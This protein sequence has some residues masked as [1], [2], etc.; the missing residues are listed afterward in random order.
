[1]DSENKRLTPIKFLADR[2]DT[3]WGSIEYKLAD[4]GFIDSMASEGWLGG[5]TI[6]DIMQT[7]LERIS[8]ETSFDWYG[9]QFPVLIKRISAK[10][11]TPF[12]VNADDETAEQR[13]DAFGKTALWYVLEAGKDA[14]LFLGFKKEVGARQLFSAWEEGKVEGLMHKV[15]P[16]AGE[17]YLVTPGMVHAAKDVTLLEISEASELSFNLET[18]LEEAFDIID[19]GPWHNPLPKPDG[20]LIVATPQFTVNLIGVEQPLKS[21]RDQDDTFL[22]YVTAAG[23]AIIQADGQNYSVKKGEL[24][25]IP[26]DV[27]DF[28]I[29]PAAPGTKVI[30]VR[31]DPRPDNDIVSDPVDDGGEN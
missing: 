14:A 1:M 31:M 8:G 16:A 5:N 19:L 15:K 3:P 2:Q 22:L 24:I 13:Y 25:L 30:E 11:Q 28:A 12:H 29:L 4:L 18:D 20:T 10:S 21:H 6:S 27:T 26:A 17:F 23:E 7:F 9:T